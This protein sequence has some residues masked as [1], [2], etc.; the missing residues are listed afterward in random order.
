MRNIVLIVIDTLRADHL[1]CYG[2]DRP[3]SPFLDSLARK[4]LVLDSCYSASNFTAPA[5]TSLFTAS[6]PSRHE[7]YDFTSQ[8]GGSPLTGCLQANGLRTEGVVTFRFF[9]NLLAKVWGEL[10]A[11]TDGRSFDYSTEL[12]QAVSEGAVEWLE[13]NGKQNPFFLF[14]HYDGPHAPYRLPDSYADMFDTVDPELVEREIRDILFPL[15]LDRIGGANPQ[16]KTISKLHDLII[17]INRKGRQVDTPTRAWVTDKYDASIRYNDDQ[18]AKVFEALQSLGLQ[19]DTVVAVLSDHGEELWDHGHFGHG[20][21]HMYDE[22][23]RTVG[24]IHDPAAPDGG[25]TAIP[26][27][28]VQIVPTLLQ[29]AGAKDLPADLADLD[30]RESVQRQQAGGEPEPVF[31]VGPFKTVAR[32][33]DLKLIHTRSTRQKT[34][35]QKLRARLR[36]LLT[37]ELGSELFDLASDPGEQRNLIGQRQLAGPLKSLLAD[38]FRTEGAKPAFTEGSQ[39]IDADEKARIE[40]EMKDLGYM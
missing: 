35:S 16:D 30:I 22:I 21:V 31:C 15:H 36:M 2:Y 37:R 32:R 18:V 12:P 14:L 39:D 34:L 4:S 33:G 6:Y 28:H 38:H 3:T 9:K 23:V 20:G 13:K 5:F 7:I 24:L 10:E 27:N 11:V 17:S 25:R 1:G 29:L 26:V 8:A 19:E 40:N